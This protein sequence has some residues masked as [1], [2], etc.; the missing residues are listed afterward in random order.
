MGFHAGGLSTTHSVAKPMMC[1]SRFSTQSVEDL[2]HQRF[3]Q[4]E[5]MLMSTLLD[6]PEWLGVRELPLLQIPPEYENFYR[7][8]ASAGPK[9]V[10]WRNNSRLV[11]RRPGLWELSAEEFHSHLKKDSRRLLKC[12]KYLAERRRRRAM[13]AQLARLVA[14]PDGGVASAVVAAEVNMEVAEVSRNAPPAPHSAATDQEEIA[15]DEYMAER[16]DA[17]EF[18]RRKAEARAK[19]TAEHAPL[20][21][22]ER[23]SAEYM[24]AVSARTKAEA[25]LSTSEAAAD[26]AEAKLEAVLR[27]LEGSLLTTP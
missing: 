21:E 20:T 5:Y 16:I 11:R 17:A 7:D 24:E 12:Q 1:M 14:P 15:F 9:S 2:P 18:D 4:K 22:L 19:A 6:L 10:R 26:A 27:V 8:R 25:A 13:R 3:S 23:A